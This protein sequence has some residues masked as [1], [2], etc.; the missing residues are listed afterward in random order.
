M[1]V[2]KD[3]LMV[4]I[5]YQKTYFYFVKEIFFYI[6]TVDLRRTKLDS[7]FKENKAIFKLIKYHR[8]FLDKQKLIVL[9]KSHI[10]NEPIILLYEKKIFKVVP[11]ESKISPCTK[12]QQILKY[13]IVNNLS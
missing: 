11:F 5:I 8:F 10:L 7:L 2:C 13:S 4:K 9:K 12:F 1:S 3:L 6:I